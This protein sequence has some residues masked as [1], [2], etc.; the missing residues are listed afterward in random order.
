M[1]N[2]NSGVFSIHLDEIDKLYLSGDIVSGSVGLN[3]TRG[4]L[5]ADQICIQ[6]KGK[7]AYTTLSYD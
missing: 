7:I 4:K 6:L 2:G 1:G 3:I 5:E